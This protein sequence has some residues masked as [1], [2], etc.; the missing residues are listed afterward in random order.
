MDQE[1]VAECMKA[2]LTADGAWIHVGATTNRGVDGDD[3]LPHPRPPW[4]RIEELTTRYLGPV[5]RAGQS[6]LPN[7][8][9]SG[10]EDVMRQAGY[11]GPTKIEVGG[12]VVAER[13]A[14]DIV[15]SVF[16]L[17]SSAPHLLGDRLQ[18]FEADLRTLLSEASPSGR[19]SERRRETGVV[20][21]RP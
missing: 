10:E 13:S 4:G 9:R 18:S 2:V 11:R 15:A 14:D 16:S 6:T 1:L 12:G 3:P 19:F 5:R 7:G 17:S 8:N 20:I 21:W